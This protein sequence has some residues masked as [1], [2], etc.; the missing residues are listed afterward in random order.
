MPSPFP[1]M[2]PYLEAP[3]IWPD[4]H[5]ALAAEIRGA[6]N[7]CLPAPFYARLEMR[8]EVGIV[9]EERISRRIVPDVAVARGPAP[10]IGSSL[11]VLDEPRTEVSPS[12]EVQVSSEPL[13]HSFVEIRDPSRGHQL[14]TLIEI[15]SPSNKQPG[16]DR[17]SYLQEQQ[18]VLESDASLIEL[19]LLRGGA[20]LLTRPELERFVERLDPPPHYLVVVNR[21]WR[22][23]GVATAY[24]QVFPVLVT[25]PLPCISVPL[26]EGLDEPRLDL[27]F[28]F[29]RAYDRGPYQRGAVDYR[30]PPEPPLPQELA[31]WTEGRVR[32]L[33]DAH[34]ENRET[35][36]Q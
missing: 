24:Q 20:R 33:L 27:Q 23:N 26:R 31:A 22:R 36:N 10:A 28:V 4:F 15:A 6:L 3:D 5:D 17:R 14:V 29:N 21:A 7:Q 34:P 8:P 12:F 35:N 1:G 18:E 13:Q 9:E 11:A 16:P 25:G 30:C 32:P 2:D 19:D